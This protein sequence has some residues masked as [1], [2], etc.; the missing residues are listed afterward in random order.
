MKPSCAEGPTCQAGTDLTK[1]IRC[2]RYRCVEGCRTCQD[3]HLSRQKLRCDIHQ[4]ID[5]SCLREASGHGRCSQCQRYAFLCGYS[6]RSDR[7]EKELWD[8]I[9]W[10]KSLGRKPPWPTVRRD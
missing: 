9:V 10:L 4:N 6:S 3:G 2:N 8:L 7:E 5:P 1:W